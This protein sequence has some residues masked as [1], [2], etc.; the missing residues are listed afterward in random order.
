MLLEFRCS[1]HKSIRG[2]VL[3]STLAGKDNTLDDKT[4]HVGDM[5]VLRAAVIYGANG[6]GKSNFIDAIS[7]VQN[8]VINSIHYQPGQ[9]IRQIPHKLDG[10]VKESTYTVQ[11]ITQG[12]RYVYGFS[13][14]NMLVSDEYL[15][16]F[17]NNR[18]TKIF[19]RSGE[20]FS[21]GSKFR[22]KFSSCKDVLKPNR[23]LLS[24]AA[25]FSNVQE[26]VDAFNFFNTELVVYGP[27]TQDNWMNYSLHQM[28][29][30]PKMKAAVIA[31]L[32]DL[33]TGIRDIQVDIDRKKMKAAELPPFLSDEYKAMILQN[34]V[35]AITA[36][37][38]Y[39]NFETDLIHEESTGIRKLFSILCPLIDIIV[40]GKVL[41]CD[42]LESGLHESLLYGL[43]KLFVNVEPSNFA[44]MIFTTHE[45]GLLNLDLFR[46]DQIWF[47][48]MRAAD[49]STD[50]YSLAEIK[51][52]RKEENFGRG[53]IAGK[54]GAIP[55]LNL[56]FANIV[57]KM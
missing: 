20:K 49:R 46:R 44:Q 36:K 40:N 35:D 6:S 39:S 32:A 12:I 19:E 54:Y 10:F 25:N 33:G 42:E 57:S 14:K 16:F 5:K 13:L 43:V 22:G 18:Q 34:D 29:D 28:H 45:T 26:V 24:C 38:I 51:N 1:N 52:V 21:A 48:E 2:N 15:Y 41:I 55:M 3:F 7:F 8:L 37:V 23:M 31:F 50:L 53:Y 27:G 17:P 9:G 30:N 11:F 47:T 56:D 4:Y